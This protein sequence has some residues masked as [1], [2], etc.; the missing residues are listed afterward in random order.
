MT[1]SFNLYWD[2]EIGIR[3]NTGSTNKVFR[4]ETVYDNRTSAS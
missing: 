1:A 4:H 2:N 3:V